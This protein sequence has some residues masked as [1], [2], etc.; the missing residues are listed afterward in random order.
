MNATAAVDGADRC[1]VCGAAIEADDVFCEACGTNLAPGGAVVGEPAAER[2]SVPATGEGVASPEAAPVQAT[3]TDGGDAGGAG[4]RQPASGDAAPTAPAGPFGRTN[5][6]VACGAAPADI[7]PDGYCTQCGLLQ[8]GPRDHLEVDLG[9]AAG[10][11]DRGLRHPK[12]EDAFHLELAGPAA[13][14]GVVAVVCDG[15]SSSVHAE[16]AAEAAATAA[17]TVLAAVVAGPGSLAQATVAA[18]DAANLAVAA[19]PWT[20]RGS[21]ASPS[22]TLVSA[23]CRAGEVAV[24][25]I[26]DSRVY[27]IGPS[28]ELRQLSVDDSWAEAQVAAGKMT[29]EEAEAD[30]RSHAITRWVGADAPRLDPQVVTLT[31]DSPGRL[32]L[33]S[34]GL[35]NY[36]PTAAAM[37]ELLSRQPVQEPPIELARSLTEFARESGGHDNITVVVIDLPGSSST[38][39]GPD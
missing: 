29:E 15:V 10:V 27:W 37:A 6:C 1:P 24:G 39:K 30:S 23:A 34:D 11:T 22:C 28:G 17:A 12:N 4:D 36:A 2:P 8:P 33:C 9:W 32:L 18:A 25:W 26:G 38:Q 5:P 21:L 13:E 31:P 3:A 14:H 7:D 20:G 16:E 19:L 35:W